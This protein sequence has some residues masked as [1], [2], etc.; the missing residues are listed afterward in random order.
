[1]ITLR[2]N[3]TYRERSSGLPGTTGRRMIV[4]KPVPSQL[5][6]R[7]MSM[8]PAI[9]SAPHGPISIM[10][11]SSTTVLGSNSGLHVTADPATT[12]TLPMPSQLMPLGM[13]MLQGG[14]FSSD[15]GFDYATVKYDN[16][17]QQ[18]WVARYNGPGNDEDEAVSI[19]VD[20]SGNVHVTGY[21]VGSGTGNDY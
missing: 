18:Q 20:A 2:L 13:S 11:R 14:S 12:W 1:M 15:T 9:A 6:P 8:S 10:L 16:S 19:A 4:I 5:M 21:S 3:T 7:A 17:G